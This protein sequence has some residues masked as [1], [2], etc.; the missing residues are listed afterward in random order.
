VLQLAL[1]ITLSSGSFPADE[2]IATGQSQV[3]GDECVVALI[4]QAAVMSN[5]VFYQDGGLV[6]HP[7]LLPLF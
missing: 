6:V 1:I 2:N 3:P 4:G 7:S 5:H